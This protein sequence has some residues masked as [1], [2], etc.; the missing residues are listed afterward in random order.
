GALI[1]VGARNLLHSALGLVV[2]LVGVAA[3]YFL[4]E[5]EFLAVVQILI[6]VGAIAVLF[7]FAVMLTRG[8]MTGNLQAF[9]GQW[10]AAAIVAVLLFGIFF[11]V[12]IGTR[13]P[14][15]EFAVTTDLTPKIGEQ[16]MTTYVLPFEVASLLLLAAL[17]GAIVIARE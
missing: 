9:N 17:V 7:L 5:A 12:A 11:F 10:I 14:L 4:L 2:A 13:W 15:K 8:L 6:Y 3:I 1:T 16:L